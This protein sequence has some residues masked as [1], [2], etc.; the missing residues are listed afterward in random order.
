MSF[1][2]TQAHSPVLAQRALFCFSQAK[3][4]QKVISVSVIGELHGEILS[5]RCIEKAAMVLKVSLQAITAWFST[6]FS[7]LWREGGTFPY[8]ITP[9]EAKSFYFSFMI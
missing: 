7:R 6:V 8:I 1:E 5:F 4:G 9:A 3:V 2:V